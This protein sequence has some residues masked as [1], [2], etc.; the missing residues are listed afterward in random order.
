VGNKPRDEAGLC[1]GGNTC[2]LERILSLT[3]GLHFPVCWTG[4]RKQA[5]V[6]MNG[7]YD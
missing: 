7:Q 3:G 6:G 4:N 1:F 2:S 5:S